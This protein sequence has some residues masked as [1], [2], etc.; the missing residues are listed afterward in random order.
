MVE[1]TMTTRDD[2]VDD[3]TTH[4]ASDVA[5]D[6][7]LSPS[8]SDSDSTSS[9]GAAVNLYWIPLGAGGWLVRLN[10]RIYES[11]CAWRERRARCE[12][13]HCALEVTLGGAT[14]VIEM[15]PIP[16]DRGVDRGVVIEGPV[17]TRALRRVRRLRYEVRC[18]RNGAIDDV[19]YVVDGPAHVAVDPLVARRVI[20]LMAYVPVLV[21]GRD[22]W[23]VDDMWNSNSLISWLLESSGVDAEHV[24]APIGGRA[25]G[26]RAGICL[27]RRRPP[28][29]S[30]H[31]QRATRRRSLRFRW[32]A[33]RRV[34]TPPAMQRAAS[35]RSDSRLALRHFAGSERA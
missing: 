32:N 9:P 1:A 8:T 25:P 19:R 16:D 28:S 26:W 4:A 20:D 21:W 18:W 33:P 15:T 5:D 29:T 17:G 31:A 7:E 22:E 6:H 12:L 24:T 30:G 27:A 3:P 14:T 13:Y 23:H 10:G 2:I 35:C 11:W 34:A